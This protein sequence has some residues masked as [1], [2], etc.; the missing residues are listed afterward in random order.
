MNAATESTTSET[1][2]VLAGAYRA[3]REESPRTHSFVRGMATT[4]CKRIK[5]DNLADANAGDS[6]ARPTCLTCIARDPRFR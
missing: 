5:A 3:G 1:R 4:L 2:Q 6:T